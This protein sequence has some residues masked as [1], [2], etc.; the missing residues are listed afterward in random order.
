MIWLKID[1]QSE[2]PLFLQIAR[3]LEDAI[4]T[5]IYKEESQIP[6]TNEMANLFQINPHTV[7][8]GVNRLVD[9]E[10]LY[11]KRGV[12][13][14]VKTGAVQKIQKKRAEAF[15]KTYVESLLKEAEKLNISKKELI[16]MIEKGAEY[17]RNQS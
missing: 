13:M 7:L 15:F 14:F 16:E 3:E 4:F 8:K 11:K 5:G 10:I 9:E 6:S 17:G 12:G 2:L 1:A